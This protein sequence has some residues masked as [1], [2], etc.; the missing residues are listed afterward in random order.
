V[1]ESC[2][3][4]HWVGFLTIKRY[5]VGLELFGALGGTSITIITSNE[6]KENFEQQRERKLIQ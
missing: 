5:Q 6:D 1:T 4:L 2:P 3:C